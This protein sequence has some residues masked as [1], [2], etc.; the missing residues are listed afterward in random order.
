M[1]LIQAGLGKKL[2]SLPEDSSHDEIVKLLEIEY[3]KL[4]NITGGWMLYKATGGTG[5]RKLQ[6]IPLESEGYSGKQ[7]KMLTNAGEIV[8][9][10]APLQEE[11]DLSP[12]PPDAQEFAKM[13]KKTCKRCGM[14]MPLQL[15]ASH[16]DNCEGNS[17]EHDVSSETPVTS[18]GT[19]KNSPVQ[20]PICLKDFAAD[21][22]ETHAS[23]CDEG[24]QPST[25]GNVDRHPSPLHSV[26]DMQEW[27]TTSDPKR[28]AL[29]FTRELLCKAERHAEP[30]CF[31]LDI[32]KSVEEQ[33]H[34]IL[35]F[36]KKG[37]VNWASPLQCKLRGDS[38]VGEGVNRYVLSTICHKLRNG[39][40]VNLGNMDVTRLF[41][42]EQGHLVASTSSFLV[43]SDL[44]L[45]AGRMVAH[46]FLHGG[47]GLPGLSPAVV[48]V[49][50][51]GTPETATL[52]LED[53]PDLDVRD[54]LQLLQKDDR[55]TDLEREKILELCLSWDLPGVTDGNKKWLFERL[56]L[57]AVLGRTTRQLK[58]MR[59]G[60][61]ET[62]LW[63][64]IRGRPDVVEHIF[65]NSEYDY[66]PQMILQHIVWP[67]NS[68]ED[69]EDEELDANTRSRIA[70]YL[71]QFIDNA[72][73]HELRKLLKFW[74]G[75]EIL[76]KEL[77][78]EFTTSSMPKTSTCF[79]TLRLPGHYTDFPS[80]QTDMQTCLSSVMYGFG[81]V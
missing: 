1:R 43:E 5:H 56:L 45:V 76:P 41:E 21:E 55:I 64:L 39:F 69:D 68:D 81:L 63:P 18:E 14:Y 7:L 23:F 67:Q 57:H 74:V 2:V 51:G 22:I 30:L 10:V 70:G 9:Y 50:T 72:S 79:E 54:T 61:K 78:V 12:L 19:E 15:L 42:G 36:Y 53:C 24:Y 3:P 38:A 47:P 4:G 27:M 66:S 34:A 8:L 37:N 75:W 35:F 52:K 6:I 60:L 17:L 62:G 25:S 32:H 33:D 29:H 40:H 16:V 20:C 11:M 73:A 80:F 48:H 59:K 49:L 65:P 26:S 31:T 13:P 28:A 44:F 46:S 58:Q 71:R 77:K